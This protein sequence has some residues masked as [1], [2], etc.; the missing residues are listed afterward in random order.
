MSGIQKKRILSLG[1][2]PGCTA[3]CLLLLQPG[4]TGTVLAEEQKTAARPLSQK[5]LAAIWDS[6]KTLKVEDIQQKKF[7][8]IDSQIEPGSIEYWGVIT[9]HG[10]EEL[11]KIS[12]SSNPREGF[13]Y[14]VDQFGKN[15]AQTEMRWLQA[16][17]GMNL[18]PDR[19]LHP[20]REPEN[21][22]ERRHRRDQLIFAELMVRKF[23]KSPSALKRYYQNVIW[24]DNLFKPLNFPVYYGT[25]HRQFQKESPEDDYWWHAFQFV[26]MAHATGRD[27]LLKDVKPEDLKPRFEEWHTWFE[28]NGIKI[29]ADAETWY[30]KKNTDKNNKLYLNLNF[31]RDHNLPPLR[32]RPEYPFPDWKGPDPTTPAN[33]ISL[34]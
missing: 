32:V 4:N 28:Q 17:R 31:L 6:I 7:P 12:Q 21:E 34:E 23:L 1:L 24:F 5:E 15:D 20:Y 16:V 8:E 3:L 25:I 33:Y 19:H 22:Y 14:I 26:L 29:R 11:R 30:W 18:N 9:A 10:M 2:L 13:Q 27:D